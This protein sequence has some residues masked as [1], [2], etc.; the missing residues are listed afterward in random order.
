MTD[1]ELNTLVIETANKAGLRVNIDGKMLN[2]NYTNVMGSFPSLVRFASELLSASKPAAPDQGYVTA[3]IKRMQDYCD[4]LAPPIARGLMAEAVRALL[5]TAPAAPAESVE[6]V[7]LTDSEQYIGQMAGISTAA[8]GY[9]KEGDSIHPSLDT[10]ALRDVA[11][12]YAKYA[13]LH[14]LVQHQGRGLDERADIAL[15]NKQILNICKMYEVFG[16][17]D[18]EFIYLSQAIIMANDRARKSRDVAQ[19]KQP[20]Q[21][22]GDEK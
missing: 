15:T 12:L 14:K 20:S 7:K 22:S 13:E 1:R 5:A 18:I 19:S 2:D 10:V 8:L 16:D 17:L 11:K 6:Q 21:T 4:S 3:L 9:W